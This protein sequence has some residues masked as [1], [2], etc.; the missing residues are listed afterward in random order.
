MS[1]EIISGINL[2]QYFVVAT[3]QVVYFVAMYFLF[4][5]KNRTFISYD[6]K[7]SLL[8]L[9]LFHPLDDLSK[10]VNVKTGLFI[11]S[12]PVFDMTKSYF[13]MDAM[14]WFEFNPSLVSLEGIDNFTFENASRV[15]KSN[16]DIRISNDKLFV[17]YNVMVWFS[18]NLDNRFFPMTDHQVF[19]VITNEHYSPNEIMFD[20]KHSYF[21]FSED[22]NTQDWDVHGKHVETGYVDLCLEEYGD[23][24]ISYPRVIFTLDL[25]KTGLRKV[26][27]IVMPILLIQ[28]LATI[29]PLPLLHH[30]SSTLSISIGA[31]T[32]LLAYRYVI[33]NVSPN[34]GYFTLAEHIY[35]VAL[36]MV[37]ITFA[38]TLTK[39]YIEFSPFGVDLGFFWFPF[40]K[41]VMF[42]FVSY[43]LFRWKPH[44]KPNQDKALSRIKHWLLSNKSIQYKRVTLSDF[45]DSIKTRAQDVSPDNDD[46]LHPVYTE[47]YHHYRINKFGK[48]WL[49]P[50]RLSWWKRETYCCSPKFIADLLI[51]CQRVVE[52]NN[53]PYLLKLPIIDDSNVVI[54]GDISGSFHALVSHLQHLNKMNILDDQLQLVR[55]ND[56]I[57]FNGNVIEGSPYLLETL[58]LVMML[59]L[60]NP[61]QVFY[62]AGECERDQV[63]K[64]QAL[65]QEI[66]FKLLSLPGDELKIMPDL[67]ARFLNSL[68][69]AIY[70]QNT[71]QD[72]TGL[73][74]ISSC[75][76]NTMDERDEKNQLV[77]DWVCDDNSERIFYLNGTELP[78]E[79]PAGIPLSA[80]IQRDE[81][82]KAIRSGKTLSLCQPNKGVLVWSI[83]SSFRLLGTSD[84]GFVLLKTCSFT[85]NWQLHVYHQPRGVLFDYQANAFS[86]MYGDIL[87]G[88]STLLGAMDISDLGVPEMKYTQTLEQSVMHDELILNST[89]DLSKTASLISLNVCHG[90]Y[91]RL[92]EQNGFGGIHEEKLK[93]VI[94]DDEYSP[95]LARKNVTHLIHHYPSKIILSPVGTPTLEAYSQLIQDK[96][97]LVMFP[98]SGG[99]LLRK[100]EFD[101]I[102]YFRPSFAKEGQELIKFAVE[103]KG[104]RRFA[105]FYQDD[106]YGLGV[107]NGVKQTLADIQVD[108]IPIPYQRNNPNIERGATEIRNFNADAILFFS[109]AAPSIALIHQ[110]GIPQVSNMSLIAISYACNGLQGY[111]KSLNLTLIRTHLVPPLDADIPIV[112]EYHQSIKMGRFNMGLSDESLEGYINMHLLSYIMESIDGPI[113]KEK[114]IETVHALKPFDYKGLPIQFNPMTR[115]MYNEIWIES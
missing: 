49:S 70:L 105:V 77:K 6:P 22:M 45:L 18:A 40:N 23:R 41:T 37:F 86:M 78:C 90:I 25:K 27:L 33:N 11:K 9:S 102:V 66:E 4:M 24:T 73:V 35:N 3:I 72:K 94:F 93:L 88:S 19:I 71:K 112:N 53:T 55:P 85:Q 64:N 80:I 17:K 59:L 111:L 68:P 42:I 92:I 99:S 75:S 2:S 96:K 13:V 82:L 57:I 108:W 97:M 62:I 101:H 8:P 98:V 51:A 21:D 46:P 56:Y 89:M 12:F 47:F 30:S 50:W 67:M 38:I 87:N 20:V 48:T 114:I 106:S 113:T 84:T 32:G 10:I 52:L 44:L 109:T 5:V 69:L 31:I 14:I 76:L 104:V 15:I 26:A 79:F 103:Q 36:T 63:W 74:R 115:E 29:A 1:V 7:P 43:L 65:A 16:P 91:T 58:S 54:F 100:H 110:L 34:V 60:K 61:D 39:I 107:L 28:Y 81:T 95:D 83:C